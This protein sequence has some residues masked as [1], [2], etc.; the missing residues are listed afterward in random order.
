M[1]GPFARWWRWKKNLRQAEAK[2][3]RM[4]A[5]IESGC[6][7]S[8]LL[9]LRCPICATPLHLIVKRDQSRGLLFCPIKYTATFHVGAA[10]M[11]P[12][13][14][15]RWWAKYTADSDQVFWTTAEE[16]WPP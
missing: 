2:V 5:M 13:V 15:P 4:V 9:K 16:P 8:D 3:R 12:T 1:L 6:G 11:P 7:E 10:V 14:R